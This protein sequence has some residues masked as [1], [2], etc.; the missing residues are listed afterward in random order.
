M[1]GGGR[2]FCSPRG[3]GANRRAYGLPQ[4]GVYRYPHYARGSF[5]PGLT[6]YAPQISHEQEFDFLKKQAEAMRAELK[7]IEARMKE[8]AKETK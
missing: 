8:L 3:I 1:T 2:G 4:W 7:D 6:P 5:V